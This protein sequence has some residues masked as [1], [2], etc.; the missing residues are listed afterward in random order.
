MKWNKKYDTPDYKCQDILSTAAEVK[1]KL[2][3][4]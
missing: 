4:S 3:N 2:L 1:Q